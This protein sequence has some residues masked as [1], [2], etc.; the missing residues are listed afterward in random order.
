VAE[1]RKPTATSNF[2]VGRRESH[3]ASAFYARFTPPATSSASQIGHT[4]VVNEIYCGDIR[5]MQQVTPD[6]VALVVTSPPYFAGKEY[7]EALGHGNIP[8]SYNAYRKMLKEVFEECVRLLEPGGRIAVNVANLGRKP[9]RSLS[10]DVITILQ[11]DL[12][13]LLRGEI[14]WQKAHGAGGSCAWGSFQSA[15]NPVL[16]DL[17]ERIIVASKG[18]FDRAL[19]RGVRHDRK[20][21]SEGS[22]FKDEFMEATVDLWDI[23]AESATRVGHPAPFPVELPQRLIELYTYK[24]DLVLDPFMGSGTTAVAAVRTERRYI[25]YDTD[26]TYVRDAKQRVVQEEERLSLQ[27]IAR[28]RLTVVP[29]VELESS[30]ETNYQARAVKEGRKAEEIADAVLRDCGFSDIEK[31]KRF[32]SGVEVNMTARDTTGKRRTDT[33]WK[34]LGKAA[35][36]RLELGDKTPSLLLLTTDLPPRGSAGFAALRKARG[37]LFIDVLEMRDEAAQERLRMYAEGER[38]PIGDLLGPNSEVS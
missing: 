36:L 19:T 3:D 35:V 22:I 4:K 30:D 21:P 25:G 14:I 20:L 11:D 18:R 8:A 26:E 34:A 32:R 5:E 12:R 17:T 33:M 6:S 38:D 28:P 7:E 37:D 2:G 9:Y 29:E 13:L 24:G 27:T 10:A 1:R 31:N 23:P 16:R 15:A